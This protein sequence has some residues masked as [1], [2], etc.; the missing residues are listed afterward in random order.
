MTASE[1]LLK[2]MELTQK[3]LEILEMINE[4]FFT[5]REHLTTV[6]GDTRYTIPSYIALEN[7]VNHL[8]AAFNNLVNAPIT[9]EAY[10][11]FDGNSRVIQMRGFQQAPRALDMG[12]K[13]LEA[14]S[15]FYTEDTNFFKDMLSPKPYIRLDLSELDDDITQV[16]VKK[17]VPYDASLIA[18]LHNIIS[19][20]TNKTDA[21][22]VLDYG[23]VMSL[24]QRSN[25]YKEGEDYS[26]YDSIYTLPVRH[27][28]CYGEYI[29]KELKEDIVDDNLNNVITVVL[30][31]TTPTMYTIYDNFTTR[32]LAVG[33]ILTTYNGSAR[34]EILEVKPSTRTLKLMVQSG[35]Y[36][37][38]LPD[39]TGGDENK[40]SD[41]S[42]LRFYKPS[43]FS[44][45]KYLNLPLEEDQYV[46][47]C[48][49]P[50][51][52]R[53][54]TQAAWNNGLFIDTDKL[55]SGIDTKPFREYYNSNVKNL[56]DTIN[57]LAAILPQ[58]ITTLSP[59]EFNLITA[60]KPFMTDTDDTID[61]VQVVQINKHLNEAE[62]IQTIRNLY[63]QKQQY[64]VD[65]TECQNKIATLTAE[66]SEISFDDMSG[67]RT[68]I[69][70]QITD[71]KAQQNEL[72]ASINTAV[73]AIA[74]AANDSEVPI[75]DG[76][77]RIRGYVDVDRFINRN[78]LGRFADNIRAV[79]VRYRYKNP[80]I[81]ELANVSTI[82][83]FL[84]TEWN[85]Y[86]AGARHKTASYENGKYSTAFDEPDKSTNDIKFN[87]IDIP[88]TQGE[89]VDI[90]TR[91]IW[92]FGY[93]FITIESDWSDAIT[94]KFPQELAADVQITTIL[95][96]NNDD[97]ETYRFENILDNHGIT[98]HAND[99]ID[100]QNIRYFHKPESISS[101]FY[102]DE[103]RIIPLLDKLKEMN[104]QIASIQ[105][106]LL[107]T[108]AESLQVSFNV[109]N[110]E[111]ILR[112]DVTNVINLT[113]YNAVQTTG[114]N[115]ITSSIS[116]PM[117]GAAATT[118]GTINIKNV[119]DHTL[120]LFSMCPGARDISVTETRRFLETL[121]NNYEY[122]LGR[123]EAV[124]N[125]D[126][127]D[128]DSTGTGPRGI[129]LGENPM[130]DPTGHDEDDELGA[131]ENPG[132]TG[133]SGDGNNNN[134]SSQNLNPGDSSGGGGSSQNINPRAPEYWEMEK[135]N[136]VWTP[137]H[138]A[139]SN[140]ICLAG[141]S[142]S[143]IIK[144][145][146][147]NVA[148]N[149]AY[150]NNTVKINLADAPGYN[151][152]GQVMLIAAG[153]SVE[154]IEETDAELGLTQIT[155]EN[156]TSQKFEI[157]VKVKYAPAE[158]NAENLVVYLHT[159]LQ[160]KKGGVVQ[161]RVYNNYSLL[162]NTNNT[163]VFDT[164]ITP[165]SSCNFT[166][167]NQIKEIAI[168]IIGTGADAY[169]A[170]IPGGLGTY[171]KESGDHT[172]TSPVN[173]SNIRNI[174]FNIEF[175]GNA[176]YDKPITFVCAG[177]GVPTI[178]IDYMLSANIETQS[179]ING[180]NPDIIVLYDNAKMVYI[181]DPATV[182]YDNALQ[183]DYTAAE[184]LRDQVCN[185]FILFRQKEPFAYNDLGH[186][187][188]KVETEAD[189][190]NGLYGL[191]PRNFQYELVKTVGKGE[192][193]GYSFVYAT[194]STPNIADLCIKSDAAHSVLELGPGDSLSVPV[195]IAYI[196]KSSD[197]DCSYTL[198]FDIRNSLYN[199]PLFYQVTLAARYNQ[200]FADMLNSQKASTANQVSY[201]PV[202]RS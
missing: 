93:P 9:G 128:D 39:A 118:F 29:V 80:G 117:D 159:L 84:F 70:A 199:D 178:N 95:K 168:K 165:A 202:I 91:I 155:R 24:V 90:Q 192:S 65:L 149:S 28:T 32:D 136:G 66:L 7:K 42:K 92:D 173:N 37:N 75:E 194:P 102:T 142:T 183:D 151:S 166:A 133:G 58:P 99:Y 27:L 201:N 198:G 41:Y 100:D 40:V 139:N 157:Y 161:D 154:E 52:S 54:N 17:L 146:I 4:S 86:S 1:T 36:V 49:A 26:M 79:E 196:A 30:D 56:G 138:K 104:A 120:R 111:Y 14:M 144:V 85:L 15:V 64:K 88:I 164:T 22:S 115:E 167:K 67:S 107:G 61:T 123:I 153:S 62:N 5:R 47:I 105:D 110:T 53:M 181:L 143:K 174:K 114:N 193:L 172:A 112:P 197:K 182:N 158:E 122:A 3:N 188:G 89:Q 46:Y 71:L 97:I 72:I 113:A 145:V 171:F 170:S 195:F 2:I 59:S 190:E 16:V 116:K 177:N 74:L 101:G 140:F 124:D 11:N 25:L 180:D 19:T 126:G 163:G 87:Q 189:K 50:L 78:G 55:T 68:M 179:I 31:E 69:S 186:Y 150:S 119:T 23:T 96:E 134:S 38:I 125:G 176:T 76:K 10:A 132:S 8:Q 106:T 94:V 33:D 44:E 34:L 109:N 12:E 98:Q 129:R 130:G 20:A 135:K 200:T 156:I 152:N 184:S 57:E 169:D 162:C 127:G 73:D 175:V 48:V 45:D 103:R 148:T 18:S 43:D 191:M 35:E 81:A 13:N 141:E 21:V 83:N 77:F 187:S 131:G 6:V 160:G 121:N 51:N 63:S 137:T 185:Q 82:G 60:S 108:Y 147:E